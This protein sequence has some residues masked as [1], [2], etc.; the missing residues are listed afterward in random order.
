MTKRV[1]NYVASKRKR[2]FRKSTNIASGHNRRRY[3]LHL[4]ND[5]RELVAVLVVV[6]KSGIFTVISRKRSR[7]SVDLMNR[8]LALIGDNNNCRTI[9]ATAATTNYVSMAVLSPIATSTA[10]S[11]SCSNE[12][13]LSSHLQSLPPPSLSSSGT[14]TASTVDHFEQHILEPITHAMNG[15]QMTKRPCL[16][17]ACKACKKKTVT[18]DR[19]KAATLRE[20]RRLRKV[21]TMHIAHDIFAKKK[22][23]C[24][25]TERDGVTRVI[26][27]MLFKTI[28]IGRTLAIW[29]IVW[30]HHTLL[31][32]HPFLRM[33]IQK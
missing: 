13:E 18:V 21:S 33:I 6:I 15:V 3:K 32:F 25:G 26:S 4:L 1:N 28:L 17:W 29:S 20:R 7:N 11:S 16:T 31:S 19:R 23:L 8:Q 10:S 5:S 24:K 2:F 12:D 30:A 22:D 14:S 27:A 9:P